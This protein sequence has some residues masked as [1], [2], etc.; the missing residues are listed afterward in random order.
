MADAPND[1]V[2][3]AEL[4]DDAA[5]HLMSYRDEREMYDAFECAENADHSRTFPMYI[6]RDAGRY[7]VTCEPPEDKLQAM[8]SE[9][10]C[11]YLQDTVLPYLQDFELSGVYPISFEDECSLPGVLA[12]SRPATARSV[13]LPDCYQMTD[14]EDYFSKM[15]LNAIAREGAV[16]AEDAEGDAV[17]AEGFAFVEKTFESKTPKMVFAGASTGDRDPARNERVA[18]C[19]WS[20]DNRDISDFYI[21]DAVQMKENALENHLGPDLLR[22]VTRDY[23]PVPDQLD[24]RYVVSID[25]NTAAW[26]RPVWA[27]RSNSVLFRLRSGYLCDTPEKVCWY[28]PLMR[29]D[30]HYTDVPSLDYMRQTFT[31]VNSNPKIADYITANANQFANRFCFSRNAHVG[32]TARLFVTH[33]ETGRR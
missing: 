30:E 21:T 24:Y 27:M 5:R 23:M 12:F 25:G 6:V 2:R 13:L 4:A 31:F 8:R 10:V 29:A 14:Y 33:S 20:V 26:D 1:N 28:Y 3:I 9:Q 7:R 15:A 17:A 16:C 32:Y 11:S 18:A 22:S 19:M